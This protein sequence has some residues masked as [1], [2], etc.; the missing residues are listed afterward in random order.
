MGMKTAIIK[1]MLMRP[2][3]TMGVEAYRQGKQ[4]AEKGKYDENEFRKEMRKLIDK[5][6]VL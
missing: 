5:N 1:R 6:L 3:L 2:M 4:D